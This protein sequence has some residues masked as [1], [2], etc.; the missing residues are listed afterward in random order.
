VQGNEDRPNSLPSETVFQNLQSID[1][2]LLP[3]KL[4]AETISMIYRCIKCSKLY[5][6][7]NILKKHVEK[8]HLPDLLP[9]TCVYGWLVCSWDKYLLCF[10]NHCMDEANLTMIEGEDMQ[11]SAYCI[12]LDSQRYILKNIIGSF[13]S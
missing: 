2:L 4:T 13:I 9:L 8:G 3:P 1:K 5:H 11:D 6:Y 7:R 10:S 12:A